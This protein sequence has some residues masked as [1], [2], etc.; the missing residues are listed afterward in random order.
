[1]QSY[2]QSVHCLLLR[3]SA[4]ASLYKA[5]KAACMC[6]CAQYQCTAEMTEETTERT[7]HGKVMPAM[8]PPQCHVIM[9]AAAIE[10]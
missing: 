7:M 8:V 5:F 10:V 2:T 1:M 6:T 3:A 4:L 9:S